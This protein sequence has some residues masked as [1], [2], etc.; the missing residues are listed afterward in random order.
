[1]PI[2]YANTLPILSNPS[3]LSLATALPDADLDCIWVGGSQTN[4]AKRRECPKG[5]ICLEFLE[6][7]ITLCLEVV[8]I[9]I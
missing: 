9:V 1:M 5:L 8:V 4:K 3:F 6:F 7:F 2:A